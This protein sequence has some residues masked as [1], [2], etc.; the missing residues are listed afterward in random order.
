M[1]WNGITGLIDALLSLENSPARFPIKQRDEE[2][3]ED[4]R[5]MIYGNKRHGYRIWFIIRGKSVWI[6]H[7]VHAA[8]E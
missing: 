1:L 4:Y 2:S 5:Q 8:R 6:G 7:V 3:S